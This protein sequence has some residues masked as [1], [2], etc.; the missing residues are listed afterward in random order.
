MRYNIEDRA[1]RPLTLF[2]QVLGTCI[3]TDPLIWVYFDTG[4]TEWFPLMR[5]VKEFE[6]WLKLPEGPEKD[7]E[8]GIRLN[9][10]RII[11]DI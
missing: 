9:S 10:S 2:Y 7:S 5:A 4:N 6:R 8:I 11:D 1:P 3:Y